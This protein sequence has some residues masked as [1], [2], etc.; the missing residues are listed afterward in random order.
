MKG[1]HVALIVSSSASRSVA[2]RSRRRRSSEPGTRTSRA[3]AIEQA[4]A[5]KAAHL[6]PAAP[7][8]A[9][10]YVTRISDTFLSGQTALARVLAERVLGRRLHARRRLHAA[11]SAPTT[12]LDV[13]GSF[14]FSGYKRIETEFI[15]P[16]LFA[17]RGPLS[18]L[19]GWREATQVGFYGL[20]QNT[21]QE[22]LANYGFNAAVLRRQ[23]RSLSDAKLLHARRRRRAVAVEAGRR[24][25]RVRR[26]SSSVHAGD[27]A[28]PR[29]VSRSI[30]TRRR[31]SASTRGR[32]RGYARRGGFY[33]VT[34]PRLHRQ[35]RRVRLR[36]GRLRGDSAHPDPARGLGARVHG[37]RADDLRQERPADSVLHDAVARRRLRPAR[38]LQLA[39]PRSEQPAAAGASGASSSTASSTWRSSTTPARSRRSRSD[40]DLHGMK[41]DYGIGFRFHGAIATPLRIELAQ[42]QRRLRAELLRVAGVLMD[43]DM[44]TRLRLIVLLPSPPPRRPCPRAGRRFYDDD[45]IAREPE[46]RS[47]AGRQA[48]RHRAVLSS[49]PTTCS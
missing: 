29:R 42:G 45:P 47:A 5:A 15:A 8:K 31:P 41:S 35:G 32:R 44:R 30:S 20:G 13:R 9:E 10:A 19:G 21:T 37:L 34:V 16:E 2:A 6:T 49:T 22:N 12:S 27:A 24:L 48:A 17:R 1:W 4:Q 38:V 40:L 28:G 7:G 18:V 11:T 14:T 3:A 39:V 23:P 33:G 26:R 25:G 36:P 43:L 46:S